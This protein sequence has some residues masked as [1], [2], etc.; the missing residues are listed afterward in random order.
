MSYKTRLL[1]FKADP[2]AYNFV[3]D[4][5]EESTRRTVSSAVFASDDAFAAAVDCMFV[6]DRMFDFGEAF[7]LGEAHDAQT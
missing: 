2:D 6:D 3:R 7:D 1:R 5:V 4:F